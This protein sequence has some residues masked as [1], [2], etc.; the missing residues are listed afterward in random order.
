MSPQNVALALLKTELTRISGIDKFFTF[1][2]MKK[3]FYLLAVS[4]TLLSTSVTAQ[5]IKT[6]LHVTVRNGLGN[7]EQG[8]KVT[9]YK[10][11]EDY[12]KSVNPA[13]TAV[14]TN[15]EGKAI[16]KNIE[17]IEYYLFVEKGDLN[18]SGAGEKIEKLEPNRINK[19]TVVIS[20]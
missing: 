13:S 14:E 17:A 8:A 9:L 1:T 6:T 11:K 16:F 5:L 18:N 3:I 7:L 10:T 4:L 20:D 12:E 2:Y 15:K 19:L